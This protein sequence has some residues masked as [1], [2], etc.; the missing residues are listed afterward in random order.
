[1]M[2]IDRLAEAGMR[3]VVSLLFGF[4]NLPMRPSILLSI[5]FFPI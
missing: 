3:K 4:L 5:F 1:M 2:L